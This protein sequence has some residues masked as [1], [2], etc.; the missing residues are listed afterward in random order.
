[1]MTVFLGELS[2]LETILINCKS[3]CETHRR[4]LIPIEF[5]MHYGIVFS[6]KV[7]RDAAFKILAK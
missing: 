4:L 3:V 1:M 6:T 7:M 5:V 2:L